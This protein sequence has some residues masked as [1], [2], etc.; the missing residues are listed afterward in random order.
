MPPPSSPV[1]RLSS[2]SVCCPTVHTI[3]SAHPL[4]TSHKQPGREEG[5]APRPVLG[6]T[7][8][9]PRHTSPPIDQQ[10]QGSAST[11]CHPA[12]LVPASLPLRQVVRV[13]QRASQGGD[14]L[15]LTPSTLS[16]VLGN[17]EGIL[18][19]QQKEV[20]GGS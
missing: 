12:R 1:P 7:I 6:D 17:G 2:C 20:R 14:P 13:G 4:A 3:A 16:P 9:T 10:P 5:R 18:Q 8:T 19:G 11:V 15:Q